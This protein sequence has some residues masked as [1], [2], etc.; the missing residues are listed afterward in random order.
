MQGA[1]VR[2]GPMP[3]TPVYGRSFGASGGGPWPRL[4]GHPVRTDGGG[5]RHDVAHNAAPTG[6]NRAR[7]RALTQPFFSTL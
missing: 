7:S 6:S 1:M 2:P 5:R 4:G 3:E